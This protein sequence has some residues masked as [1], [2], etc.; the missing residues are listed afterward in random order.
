LLNGKNNH[1]LFCFAFLI[2]TDYETLFL[3]VVRMS[4]ANKRSPQKQSV[5]DIINNETEPSPPTT[6]PTIQV[7][8]S[9]LLPIHLEY[10]LILELD[11]FP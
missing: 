4:N 11:I 9:L 10:T 1:Y 7:A 8:L 3:N 5:D 2:L 6:T